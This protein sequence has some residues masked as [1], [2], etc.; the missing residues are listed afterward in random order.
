MRYEMLL[1]QV[2]KQAA[3]TMGL[4]FTDVSPKNFLKKGQGSSPATSPSKSP[5]R[6]QVGIVKRDLVRFLTL[7]AHITHASRRTHRTFRTLQTCIQVTHT[8]NI[9]HPTH[10]M[11]TLDILLTQDM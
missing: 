11:H 6:E 5:T 7:D 1:L 2:P 9:R 10:Q 8:S 4:P 3:A